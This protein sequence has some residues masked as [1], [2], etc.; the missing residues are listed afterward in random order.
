MFQF[1]LFEIS[2]RDII[3][4]IGSNYIRSVTFSSLVYGI[5]YLPTNIVISSPRANIEN[6]TE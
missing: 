5:E 4:N 3:L 6:S 1:N 2:L